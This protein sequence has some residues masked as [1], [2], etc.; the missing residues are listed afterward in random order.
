MSQIHT[1]EE[2]IEQHKYH[3]GNGKRGCRHYEYPLYIPNRV[4]CRC[5]ACGYFWPMDLK[6][7]KNEPP[8]ICELC[9]ETWIKCTYIIRD[10]L[11]FE[12]R[13]IP[14]LNLR[15]I[16]TPI[17]Y[18]G[19][20]ITYGQAGIYR[21]EIYP[22]N[23]PTAPNPEMIK[24][25]YLTNLVDLSQNHLFSKNILQVLIEDKRAWKRAVIYTY[26][27]TDIVPDD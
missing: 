27:I 18:P 2:C 7:F 9:L 14:K 17:L 23:N 1:L 11:L 6:V 13:L 16:G 20:S 8:E 21:I 19:Q 25:V 26:Q 24:N 10:V 12:Y 5:Q 22:V 3:I 4:Y 15:K